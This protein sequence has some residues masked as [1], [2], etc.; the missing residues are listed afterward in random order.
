MIKK[1]PLF[2][3]L[4]VFSE[5]SIGQSIIR[6][7]SVLDK[8]FEDH[9]PALGIVEHN[10]LFS[11]F[12]FYK[13]AVHLG[14]KPII[15]ANISVQTDRSNVICNMTFLCKNSTG[16]KNLSHLITRSY[17]EGY[18]NDQASIDIDWLNE[19]NSSGLI[20]IS[21]GHKGLIQALL[22]SGKTNDAADQLKQLQAIFFNDVYLSIQRLGNNRDEELLHKTLECSLS[23]NTPLLA[24]NNPRFLNKGDYLALDARVCIDQSD[25]IDNVKRIKDYTNEQY[26]KTQEEM[27]NLFSDIPEALTNTVNIAKKCNFKFTTDQVAL[28]AYLPPKGLSVEGYLKREAKQG[29]DQLIDENE[30]LTK[31]YNQRL[32]TELDIIISTGFSGY[33]LIV[34]DF[35]KWSRAKNIPVGPGRGSGP[36]SLV[37][38]CLGITDIDPIRYDL[39]FERFLNP[40]RVSMPDFDIDFCVKGRDQV[41]DYVSDRYGSEMVSQIITFGTMSAKAVVRDVGRILGYPFG[42]VDQIAKLIPFE[43]GITIENA[44]KKES[45]LNERYENEEEVQAIINLALQLEGLVRNAGKHAGGVV[46]APSNLSDFMPLYTVEGDEGGTV[47]QFDK[48]DV[49]SMGLIKFDFLGLKTLTVIQTAVELIHQ[50]Q[51]D[52]QL[53]TIDIRKIPTDDIHTY[54]LLSSAKTVGVFQL[55]SMGMRDLIKRMQPEKFDDIIA[56]VALFRPGPLLSGMV[57]DFIERRKADQSRLIDYLH[58]MLESILRTTYGV[59][60]YQEQVMQIAQKLAKYTQGSA[61]ILRKAMGKKIP[62]E[63]TKQKDIFIQGAIDNDV[64]ESTAI[65]IFDL[66]EKFAGY[67][68]NKSHSVSYAFIAYQT[69]W[70]KTHYPA[71]FMAASMTADINNT[72]K[73][74]PLKEDCTNLDI[75]I[76]PP[77]INHSAYDFFVQDSESI[78]YGLGAIKGIG[79]SAAEAMTSERLTNGTYKDFFDFCSRL[80]DQ[81]LSKRT[82]EALVKSGAMDCLNENRST[83]FRSIGTGVNFANKKAMDQKSGQNNLF[84]IDG[85]HAETPPSLNRDKEWKLNDLLQ[86]EFQSL[87]FYFSGHPFDPYRKDCIHLTKGPLIQ[88]KAKM[89]KS[90][91]GSL[92]FNSQNFMEIA[93]L[94]FDVKRRGNNLIFRLD[95]GTAIIDA[96]VFGEN[97]DRFRDLINNNAVLHLNGSFRY[98]TYADTWQFVAS[99]ILELDA[100]IEKKAKTLLIKCNPDF[101]PEKLKS[102]LQAHTPGS[103]KVNV[104]YKT[105]ID[106]YKLK[107]G[108]EWTVKVTKE[109]RDR[110]TA[111]FGSGNFQFLTYH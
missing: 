67:G 36:G 79:E 82:I 54:Q 27:S 37:A 106:V 66:I 19:K 78:R 40:E 83:L 5:Y 71:Q 80:T 1:E 93:G 98:D 47:T 65:K 50:Q 10:N 49:E 59:I 21:G 7:E 95:D 105:D 58:P 68:F 60:V 55:E 53:K 61:D 13:K 35:V 100:L 63:M 108:Q 84:S 85:D 102:I 14:I 46:I 11:A 2:I 77:C 88:I 38:F 23:S 8:C 42:M 75:E 97:R 15:G 33:F 24:A 104:H 30:K 62:E 90:N 32:N 57:D 4:D 48:D 91:N 28:P 20:A 76:L 41:I 96:I 107:F 110:L 22:L 43:I 31:I 52:E 45:E 17:I 74:I 29:L 25:V 111:E 103:C 9:M 72:D 92:L 70:L 16:Y 69:A 6:I 99:E 109:L 56:L 86:G 39:L 94:V 18:R 12:K 44:L 3:H 89:E 101:D 64:K 34:S 26:F 73:I 51:S 87:G 81:K